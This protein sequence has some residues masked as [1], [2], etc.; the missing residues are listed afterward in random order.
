MTD[1]NQ[2]LRRSEATVRAIV[3][4]AVTAIITIGD[5]G[6]VRSFNPAA[7]R[8][9]QYQQHE[10]MGRNVK[11]LMPEP[12]HSEHDGYLSRYMKEGKPRIIGSGREVI[13]QRKDH[14]TFPAD[15]AVS[16][17]AVEGER[18]FVGILT[19]I[20]E[21]KHAEATNQNYAAIVQSSNDAI[22]SKDTNSIIIGW[23]PSA[24][25][26]FGYTAEEMIGC[27]ML[28]L[29]PPERFDEERQIMKK[30]FH[31]ETIK[32]FES[33]RVR[34]DGVQIDVSV[35]ISP[36]F[37]PTGKIM[38]ISNISRDI[39][40]QK[41]AERKLAEAKEAAE[42]GSRIKA[43]FVANM[44]HEIRT[45]M[46]AI[47][48][49]S[50][51]MLQ[52][53]TLSADSSKNVRT[54]FNAAKSLLCIINDVLDVSKM[55]SGKF[56]LEIVCF[57]LYN[58]LGDSIR[59]LESNAAEKD[60]MLSFDYDSKIPLRFMGDP[61]RLRQI[62]LNLVGNSIK[63]T[64]KG[65]V[66]LTV[67]AGEQTDML[68][69]SVIDTGIGMTEEQITTV[70]E[71]F[72]QADASTTR[73]FGGTGL[74][75]SIS[76]QIVELMNGK[77]W[78]ESIFGEGTTFHF[79]V[80]LPVSPNIENCLFDDSEDVSSGYISPR[81]FNIL[82]AEDIDANAT[83]VTL[84][85]VQQG[86]QIYWAKN[87][88]ETV[89]AYKKDDYD[90]ILMDVQ[91]PELDGL[92]A[93]REI[94]ALESEAGNEKRIVILALTASILNEDRNNCIEA[95]MNDVVGKPIEFGKLFS[96]M[97]KIIPAGIGTI[98][99]VAPIE[100]NINSTIDFSSLEGVVDH[101]K[102]LKTWGDAMAYDKALIA[103][104]LE[105][106][107][108]ADKMVAKLNDE[109]QMR[110]MAHA[111]RG[112]SG[113]LAMINVPMIAGEIEAALI[114]G[115]KENLDS[116]LSQL[117]TALTKVS[118]AIDYLHL[119]IA[120]Q[121]TAI[122]SFDKNE[123]CQLFRQLYAALKK[124]NPDAVEPIISSLSDYLD[125]KALTKIRREIDNFDFEE[126]TNQTHYLIK[127]LD[128]II[129]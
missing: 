114:S 125:E 42:E 100:I 123:V 21:R 67:K 48:G 3:E 58:V 121:N 118:V 80:R 4:T 49:F 44:S 112:I 8:L 57:N 27:P 116:L 93:T 20:T 70:F 84:R 38:G 36:M 37:D 56:S 82:L 9:F 59:T 102:G 86:H 26:I 75:T 25:R 73:R 35:T 19:D 105:R 78:V 71:A 60:L 2:D 74:G 61:T 113:N 15:L 128:L 101:E 127:N 110:E 85:S 53:P 17:I 46:N 106:R 50:E 77:I 54:I 87:G 22:I 115:H 72:S 7:E 107:N 104:A 99:T 39:T 33:V 69:F 126:A 14:S 43:T 55:E 30:I 76:K 120:T 32:H 28:K 29:F 111:I 95:G 65:S 52:D 124:L 119:P 92:G 1:K 10:I 90:L 11:I 89:E 23:N 51:V 16:E 64:Q 98:R 79:T 6:M 68:H 18:L 62:I 96:I 88:R 40:E 94:R 34:K 47:L 63:F 45:P 103:F 13:C 83:L 24:E 66:K 109:A 129:D 81:L 41:L 97:E 117:K 5:K 108:D 122:K 91:M 31:G 12:F